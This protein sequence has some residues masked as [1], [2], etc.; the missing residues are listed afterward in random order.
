VLPLPP[1]KKSPPPAGYTGWN[2]KD[3]GLK[4]IES[5]C[6]ETVGDFQAASNIAIHMPDDV[7]GVDVDHYNGKTGGN[8]LA[9]LE[10]QLGKLPATYVSTSRGDG[11]S[12]IRWYR[13]E[14]GLR[15][16]TG[17]GKDIEFCHK[18]HRYA[19]V[20]PSIHDKTGQKY[21][22]YDHAGEESEPPEPD[23]LA[24]LPD[25]W[26]AQFTGGEQRREQDIPQRN[27]TDEELATCLTDGPICYAATKALNKF[28][29]RLTVQPRHDSALRTKADDPAQSGR[30]LRKPKF[31]KGS[32][33]P[34]P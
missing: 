5:W 3:P 30:G 25:E 9:E 4:M 34:A 32:L 11:V 21:K 2:G 18:G 27:A 26:Q 19:V 6:N 12:G 15:W 13:V 29:T 10:K 23:N 31:G 17:P 28:E 8:T 7:I 24:W 16:P 1:K 14:P 20:W 33:G 22:W